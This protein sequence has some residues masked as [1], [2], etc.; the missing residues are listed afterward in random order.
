MSDYPYPYVYK[1]R[2]N[3]AIREKMTPLSPQH[4]IVSANAQFDVVSVKDTATEPN[5][6]VRD[7]WAL[8][9]DG[10][11]CA[12]IYGGIVNAEMVKMSATPGPGSPPPVP[13][14]PPATLDEK[15]IRRDEI[16]QMIRLLAVR[17]AGLE[18]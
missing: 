15:A 3:L 6:R 11:Y 8:R 4:G 7:R 12:V 18:K 5:G 14:E 16:D 13:S 1:A 2:V 9:S 10:Y 17:R